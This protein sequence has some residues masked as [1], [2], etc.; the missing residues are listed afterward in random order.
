VRRAPQLSKLQTQH[1]QAIMGVDQGGFIS[2]IHWGK[3]SKC[4]TLRII[5][6]DFHDPR[7]FTHISLV[8]LPKSG[9]EK[10]TVPKQKREN[11]KSFLN[12]STRLVNVVEN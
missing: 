2:L 10:K 7:P 3:G 4:C 11:C 6:V 5:S 8:S 9:M 12:C 1:K